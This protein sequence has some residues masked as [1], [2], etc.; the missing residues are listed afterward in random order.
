MPRPIAV[1][2]LLQLG[3]VGSFTA[4]SSVFSVRLEPPD[5]DTAAALRVWRWKEATLG[6]GQDFFEFRPKTISRLS[7]A[8]IASASSPS[9]LF[10]EACVL[11]NCARLEVLVATNRSADA[12]EVTECVARCLVSQITAP[13]TQTGGLQAL[14]K[15]LDSD[16]EDRIVFPCDDARSPDHERLRRSLRSS[17][18]C[19]VGAEEVARSLATIAA[20]LTGRNGKTFDPFSSRD[21]HI[22]L[23]LK[24][25]L[26]ACTRPGRSTRTDDHAPPCK[27]RL[28]VIIRS[29][30]EAGKA[31]RSASIVPSI[32]ALQGLERGNTAL[33]NAAA[34]DALD[35][36]VEPAVRSCLKSLRSLDNRVTIAD[37]RQRGFDTAKAVLRQASQPGGLA[38][39]SSAAQ[40]SGLGDPAEDTPD[41]TQ[42]LTV[43]GLS[44]REGS[45][46]IAMT[47]TVL[48]ERQEVEEIVRVLTNRL[49]HAPTMTLRQ[50]GK[51][52]IDAVLADIT[53]AA[54][55]EAARAGLLSPK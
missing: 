35:H 11:A 31:A 34:K 1:L 12:Q 40:T 38:G 9:Y 51:V 21:A 22:M 27:E 18:T 32:K 7:S 8:M 25:A 50:G 36:A 5:Q 6:N 45:S 28:G 2:L 39:G 23:Q 48:D 15:F 55:Q 44:P 20:G 52:D 10:G 49:L 41:P 17:L 33:A 19:I 3:T 16:P 26:D 29:A 30:L 43:Q 37:L 24:R 14:S 47:G 54:E 42:A 53:R 4:E 13:T 46:S